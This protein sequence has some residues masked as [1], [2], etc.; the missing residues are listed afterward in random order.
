MTGA[1]ALLIHLFR[2]PGRIFAATAAADGANLP[3]DYGPWTSFKSLE[4][5]AGKPQPGLD[6]DACLEDVH[7]HGFHLTDAH[8]R[9]TDQA[10]ATL[11]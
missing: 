10:V 3:P 11:R 8:V 1:H 2:G 6:V 4:I 5:E 7:A 9:I